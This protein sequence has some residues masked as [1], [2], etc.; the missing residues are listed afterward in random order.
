[1]PPVCGRTAEEGA[2]GLLIEVQHLTKRYGSHLAVDDLSFFVQQGVIY[3]LLGPN[4]AGKS[5]TMNILTGY[6]SATGGTVTIDG[7]DVLEEPGEARACIG[8]LPE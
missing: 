5:T 6:I 8:Y 4:G 3:G 2:C 1:M 7:H